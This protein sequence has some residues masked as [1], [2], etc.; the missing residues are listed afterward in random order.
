MGQDGGEDGKLNYQVRVTVIWVEKLK[1]VG[2]CTL[3]NIEG[4]RGCASERVVLFD[5]TKVGVIKGM[6]QRTSNPPVKVISFNIRTL[7]DGDGDRRGVVGVV[8]HTLGR[9][10][11]CQW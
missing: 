1:V 4:F 6:N 8:R 11:S 10:Y 2:A 5:M 7:R 9:R 3:N